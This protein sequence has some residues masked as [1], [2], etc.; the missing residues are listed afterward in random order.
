MPECPTRLPEPRAGGSVHRSTPRPLARLRALV[1][2][3]AATLLLANAAQAQAPGQAA[4]ATAHPL[5]SEAGAQILAD[6]G[7]AFDAA[8]AIGAALAVVEPYGSGMG[9]GGFF[10]LRQAGEAA[11]YRFL[12]ARER[13]PLAATSDLYLRD[14]KADPRL[15]L[16]G[17]L[18]A[19][20]PGLPAAWVQLADDYGRLPLTASLAP[21]IRLA[22]EG[23]PIDA[24]YRERAGWRLE[25]L[26]RD[27]ESARLFLLDGAIPPLGH[28][29]RQPE[30]A[31]TLERLADQGNAG[32][33]AGPVAERLVAG[34][35]EAGGIWTRED[36]ARYETV[37]REPLVFALPDERRLI[38]APLPSAGGVAIAQSLGLLERLGWRAAPPLQ[39]VHLVVESLRRAYRDRGLLG[40]PDFIA[41]PVDHLLSDRHLDQLAASVDPRRATPSAT[42]PPAPRWWEGDHTT[43]FVV[44]DADGNAVAATVSLNLMF[45]AAFTVP[46]TGVLLNDQMDDFAADLDASNA[47]GLT[48]SRANLIAPGKRPLSSMSPTFIEGPQGLASFGTPGG[49]RI[50]SMNLL[51]ALAYLGGEPVPVWAATRRYHHQYLPDVVQY[52]AG[53]FSA[54]ERQAL[55]A[56]GHRL[57]PLERAYGNQ[58]IIYWDKRT[59]AVQA[60]S[61]PRG[62]GEALVI[63]ASDLR[64]APA[65]R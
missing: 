51:S 49:S 42:L 28:R 20:I 18:A 12:D 52:E 36:L 33:Y 9:G 3:V 38:S 23:F 34:V 45:G 11:T 64:S 37:L 31:E 8:V 62:A 16:D 25:A 40:D 7:N 53:A 60:A 59:G 15:S 55:E 14:G 27:A 29:L 54:S 44:M 43:H 6:G 61:D 4:I 32:F 30:L 19:G 2:T 21:A 5:A 63:P 65:S 50:P 24:V 56:M 57:E 13:A 1:F 41:S 35:R 22:R 17:P 39:R 10:M 47:Y 46:G 58:Q 48:G 26:Q